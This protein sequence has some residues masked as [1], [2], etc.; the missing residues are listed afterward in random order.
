MQIIYFMHKFAV[1]EQQLHF[2]IFC[3]TKVMFCCSVTNEIRNQ[4]YSRA[5]KVMIK[6]LLAFTQRPS[7]IKESRDFYLLNQIELIKCNC[8]LTALSKVFCFVF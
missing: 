8:F 6:R 4:R 2:I 7:V 1:M 3:S 5:S